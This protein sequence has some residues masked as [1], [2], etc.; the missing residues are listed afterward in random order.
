MKLSPVQW[1]VLQSVVT[2][3][4]VGF[5][6]WY[7]WRQ[8]R[9][10]TA[11]DLH[12]SV[13]FIRLTAASGLVLAT[14]LLL[15]ETWRRVLARY[16]YHVSFSNAARVWFIS[17]LG[18]FV[19]GRVWQVTAMTAM[20]QRLGIP[21]TA[22]GSASAVITIANV[23][24][25]FSLLLVVGTRSLSALEGRYQASVA[26]ATGLLLVALVAAPFTMRVIGTV[27]T[28]ALRRPVALSMPAS[29]AWISI[30][31]CAVAWLSYGVAFQ[32]FVH[33]IVG[34]A[35]GAWSAYVAA[36]T[37][38]YLIGYLSL[39]TPGGIGPREAALSFLLVTLGLATGREAAVI[40][41]ASRLWLKVLEI[42]PGVLFLL[43][44][45]RDAAPSETA[46][47]DAPGSA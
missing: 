4:L 11:A 38:S 34:H 22:A 9:E 30:V 36:Y 42:L 29:A 21:L 5:A 12:I 37:L 2:L 43:R 32:I 18:K 44:R 26:I 25:G 39:I 8:W 27:A 46:A 45:S 14:Y 33:A 20:T 13:D 28:R 19:P 6:A 35:D 41:I 3:L 15:V 1:R 47:S 7:L 10:A 31:G 16:G 23:V 24:A 17:N 40:T